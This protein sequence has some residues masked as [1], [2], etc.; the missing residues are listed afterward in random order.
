MKKYK[1][2]KNLILIFLISLA[3]LL[4]FPKLL[5]YQEYII[6]SGSMSPSIPKGSLVYIQ[7]ETFD[8]IKSGDV[9]AYEKELDVVVHRVYEIDLTHQQLKTKGD[10][11]QGVDDAYVHESMI[12][13]KV[14]LSIQFLGYF[15]LF[16][17]SVPGMLLLGLLVVALFYLL[18]NCQE[19]GNNEKNNCQ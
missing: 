12:L 4:L 14:V 11:N 5:G 7:N 1:Y 9:I 18:Y 2:I 16:I 6:K 8:E 13:G 3:V 10:A 19:G 17:K 15:V